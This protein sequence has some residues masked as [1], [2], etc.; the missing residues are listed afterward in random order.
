LSKQV[1]QVFIKP[2]PFR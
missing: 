1:H 2:V